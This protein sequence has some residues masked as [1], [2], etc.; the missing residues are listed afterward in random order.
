MS[1]DPL[2]VGGANKRTNLHGGSKENNKEPQTLRNS[3]TSWKSRRNRRF[4]LNNGQRI[5]LLT[6][7]QN[8]KTKRQ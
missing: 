3:R 5:I 4:Q 7:P 1:L 8:R 6:Q 2:C